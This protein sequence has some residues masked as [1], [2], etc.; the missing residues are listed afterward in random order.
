MYSAAI[1]NEQTLHQCILYACHSI[2]NRP[3]SFEGIRRSMIS[4]V[5]AFSDT[6]GGHC[7]H[8]L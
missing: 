7:E 6:G 1:E 4:R 3:M 5:K 8:L 2:R